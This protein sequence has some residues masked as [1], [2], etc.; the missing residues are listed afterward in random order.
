[1][2]RRAIRVLFISAALVPAIALAYTSPGKPTGFV[3]DFA[4]VIPDDQQRA[5]EQKLAALEQQTRAEL[6]IVTIPSLGG[7]TIE[8]FAVRLFEEW[9]IGKKQQDN[10]VL[11]LVALE[12]REMRIEV[13]YGLEGDLTDAQSFQIIDRILKPA[14]RSADY[15]GGLSAAAD[16]IGEILNT[17]ELPQSLD[18]PPLRLSGNAFLAIF[19]FVMF[20]FRALFVTMARTKSW[21]FG[22][23]LGG[24]TAGLAG[25]FWGSL[26]AFGLG[27]AFLVPLGLVID[28]FL[29]RMA[30][31]VAGRNN[32]IWWGGPWGGGGGFGGGGSGGGGASGRW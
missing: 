19:F 2:V 31:K 15:A 27:L 8:D 12:D 32:H 5:L 6:A 13:G 16:A 17:G 28:F 21:W 29:S 18:S 20:L 11:L 25:I 4:Q 9:Q 14:F 22:G 1:M 10:G 26:L 24:F 3:N 7:D 23:V 30:G